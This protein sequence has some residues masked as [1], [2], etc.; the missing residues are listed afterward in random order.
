MKHV[1]VETNWVVDFCA[2]PHRVIPAA[3]DLASAAANQEIRLYLPSVCL[4]GSRY[5]IKQKYQAREVAPIRDFLRWSKSKGN[6][7]DQPAGTVRMVVDEYEKTVNQHLEKIEELLRAIPAMDGVEVFALN[8]SMLELSLK[9]APELDLKP[10]DM[11][12]L[13]AVLVRSEELYKSGETDICF[14]EQDS[15]L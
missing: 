5:A 7:E 13:A 2:P 14:A 15:D 11:S 8:D 10:F 1:F 3:F 12:I 4:S 9:L 6:L